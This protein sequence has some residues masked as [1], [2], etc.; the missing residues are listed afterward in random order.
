MMISNP[1][2]FYTA[3]TLL[4]LF[5]FAAMLFNNIIYSLFSSIIV[6]FSASI[7]F[8]TLGSEYNAIIQALI[9]G[10]AVPVIIGLSVMFTTGVQDKKRKNTLTLFVLFFAVL[11]F[12]LFADTII[13]SNLKFPE[14]FN[15]MD[16]AQ[17]NAFDIISDFAK[18]IFINY[19][20]AFE[21]LSLLLTIVI[22]GIVM[23]TRGKSKGA[24][25]WK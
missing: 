16:L 13:L 17:V 6:F 7:I 18:G 8:Y 20:W 15:I 3:S 24:I 12:I 2:I 1:I 21:L 14:V 11:F 22:A 10:I 9:Y 4:I 23:V 5:A 19:V 25:K